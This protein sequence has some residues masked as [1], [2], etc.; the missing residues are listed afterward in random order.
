MLLLCSFLA[1]GQLHL[2]LRAGIQSND[3]TPGDVI[4]LGNSDG[5]LTIQDASYGLHAGFYADIGIGA[6]FIRP[7]AIISTERVDFRLTDLDRLGVAGD[8]FTERYTHLNIPLQIGTRLGPFYILGG[9]SARLFVA[10]ASD[11]FDLD[12]YEQ[13][14][15]E[16]SMGYIGGVGVQL[17][18]IGVDLRYEGNLSSFG[19]H[20]RFFGQKVVFD[21]K[22]SRLLAGL[23]LEF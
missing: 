6:F 15:E 9:P 5:S 21:D 10:G 2:G 8:L 18:R 4:G 11:L 20:M 1:S 19:D 13:Q 14:W 17:G 3:L 22:P 16:L 23:T 12:E 7:E